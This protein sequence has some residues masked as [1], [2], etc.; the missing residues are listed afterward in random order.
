MSRQAVLL[1]I[2][3]AAA[4]LWPCQARAVDSED[5]GGESEQVSTRELAP[6]TEEAKDAAEP[7]PSKQE[8]ADPQPVPEATSDEKA[9][10]AD[11]RAS[12]RAGKVRRPSETGLKTGRPVAAF[13]FVVPGGF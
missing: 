7:V 3:L 13:W 11:N 2:L 4:A 9:D 6:A 12:V 5:S 10:A 1:A 8:K